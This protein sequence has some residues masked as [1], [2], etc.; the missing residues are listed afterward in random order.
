M[1][2]VLFSRITCAVALVLVVSIV[3]LARRTGRELGVLRVPLLLVASMIPSNFADAVPLGTVGHWIATS[4]QAVLLI[5]F[6]V[7]VT[8]ML[9]EQRRPPDAPPPQM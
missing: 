2:Q 3:V 9:R 1:D 4:L 5:V 6:F 7:V 8:R